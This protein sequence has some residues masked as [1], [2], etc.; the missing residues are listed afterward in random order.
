MKTNLSNIRSLMAHNNCKYKALQSNGF[1]QEVDALIGVNLS[2]S[3]T[4]YA[5][6]LQQDMS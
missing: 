2:H 3:M 6:N 5:S 4:T 1:W